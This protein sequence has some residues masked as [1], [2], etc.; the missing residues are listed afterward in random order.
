MRLGNSSILRSQDF[1][2][3]NHDL[4]GL[5]QP[6]SLLGS[7]PSWEDS[8]CEAGGHFQ[9]AEEGLWRKRNP[10]VDLIGRQEEFIAA[11]EWKKHDL[12]PANEAYVPETRF[13]NDG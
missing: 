12:V 13:I 11:P 9:L 5:P 7:T 8:V 10:R 1:D 4:A 2:W 3:I 6:T